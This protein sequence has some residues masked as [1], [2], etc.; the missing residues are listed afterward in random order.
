[1]VID[2]LENGKR[3]YES[4]EAERR[5]SPYEISRRTQSFENVSERLNAIGIIA[6]FEEYFIKRACAKLRL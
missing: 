3:M 4:R 2:N 6:T 5:D 1:M